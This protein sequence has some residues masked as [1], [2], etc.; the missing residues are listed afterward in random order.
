MA[1]LSLAPLRE[2][3]IN[4]ISDLTWRQSFIVD[5]LNF[6]TSLEYGGRGS[7][8]V[9]IL[10]ARNTVQRYVLVPTRTPLS[11]NKWRL[12]LPPV[13]VQGNPDSSLFPIGGMHY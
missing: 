8:F 3:E 10:I 13:F 2:W 7:G 1:V 12:A 11:F 9:E 5:S 4:A 6:Q